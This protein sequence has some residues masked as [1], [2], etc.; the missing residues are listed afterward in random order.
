MILEKQI[1]ANAGQPNK[2]GR[3]YPRV[4]LEKVVQDNLDKEGIGVFGSDYTNGS[5]GLD[6]SKSAFTWSN[7][8]LEG[9]NLVAD[10]KVLS[11]PHGNILKQFASDM[12]FRSIGTATISED[13]IVGDDFKLI[14]LVAFP[15]DSAA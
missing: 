9:D 5:F 11:T 7:L 6:L 13:N 1:I 12:A 4:V 8:Q 3:I 10:I 15:K 14:G 2:N